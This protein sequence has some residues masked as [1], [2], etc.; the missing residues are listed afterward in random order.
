MLHTKDIYVVDQ[1]AFKAGKKNGV[2]IDATQDLEI[3]NSQIADL[4][5]RNPV[6]PTG[7]VVIHNSNGFSDFHYKIDEE[8]SIEY[9]HE[10]ALFLREFEGVGLAALMYD[11]DLDGARDYVE[12][13][14]Q[15]SFKTKEEFA[16]KHFAGLYSI[17]EQVSYFIDYAKAAN[18]LFADSYI[19]IQL[20]S[21]E[22]HVF[23]R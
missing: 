12:N 16:A 15:G 21:G 5:A 8:T 10:V 23:E 14:Y 6:E 22:L 19:A 13:K 2:W 9:I 4:L 7:E 18:D 3:I 11:S 1:V 17:P 20:S